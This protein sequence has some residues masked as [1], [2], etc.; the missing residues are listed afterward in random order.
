MCFSVGCPILT[1]LARI[2]CSRTLSLY[3]LY[4]IPNTI[5]LCGCVAELKLLLRWLLEAANRNYTRPSSSVCSASW[6]PRHRN[7]ARGILVVVSTLFYRHGV[8][9]DSSLV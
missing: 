3:I 4:P 5:R 7:D 1:I 8:E 9:A 6:T 2:K